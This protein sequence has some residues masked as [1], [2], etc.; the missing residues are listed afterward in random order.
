MNIKPAMLSGPRGRRL[1]IAGV[2]V[3]LA[4]AIAV[5]MV[6]RK[7]HA[8][9]NQGSASSARAVLTVAALK[10]AQQVWPLGL[11]A[12]GSIVAWQE[13]I[14]GAE[15][16]GL[17]IAA[18]HVEVGDRVRRGQVLA[19]LA[20]ETVEA[21]LRRHEA[22]LASAR[23]SLAQASANAAR[24]RQVKDS[25]ALSEQQ[26]A[27][28]FATEQTAQAAV[29]QA[30]AQLAA[31]RVT[32][33]Q[34]KILAVD[35][36]I[37]TAKNALLGQVVGVGSELFRLQRQGRLEW[38]AEVDARQLARIR[39]GNAAHVTLPGGKTLT[40]K[41]RVL[42]PTLSTSTS[43]A[44][45]LVSLPEGAVAGMFGSGDIEAGESTVLAVPEAV[46]VQRDG[47]SYVFE[48]GADNHVKRHRVE[49]G[50]RRNGMV[51]LRE[52]VSAGMSLVASGGG[53][54]GDGDLVALAKDAR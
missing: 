9:Q 31:Q 10:P 7:G 5:L 23:A 16:G 4:G 8:G 46:V 17:R 20:R 28:Y 1:V 51:E 24:A 54:L 36:G 3:I 25:G 52:G 18:L 19:E 35:D 2:A 11:A 33:Q 41:V 48:I 26:I 15:T 30:E 49:T 27:E 45:V 22:A 34:T 21:D 44:N 50:M 37:I 32:L 39:P 13:A 6:N 47:L 40:G 29:E 53:F 43:R 38:Q 14:I 12:S 42:A